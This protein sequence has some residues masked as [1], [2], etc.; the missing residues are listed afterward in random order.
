MKHSLYHVIRGPVV[1]EKTA[2]LQSQFNQVCL[3]VHHQANKPLIR[4]ALQQC[5]GVRAVTVRVCLRRG[6]LA[7]MG[8]HSGRH[9]NTKRA[10]VTL[11]DSADVEKL[12]IDLTSLSRE[13]LPPTQTSGGPES[14]S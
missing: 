3:H 9:A 12:G 8:R 6:K 1:T 5:F 11:K 13:N 4:H 2:R 10:F 14:S 7:R